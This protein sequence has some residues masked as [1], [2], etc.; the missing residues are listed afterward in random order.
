MKELGHS[1]IFHYFNLSRTNIEKLVKFNF[2]Y[3]VLDEGHKIRNP[4]ADVTLAMK[5][6][7]T[8]HRIILSGAPIQVEAFYCLI[9]W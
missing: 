7:P 8:P 4:D 1:T 3:V 5:T 6:F 9:T 2:E